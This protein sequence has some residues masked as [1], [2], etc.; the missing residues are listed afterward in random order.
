MSGYLLI[1]FLESQSKAL[2]CKVYLSKDAVF[3][4]PATVQAALI[5]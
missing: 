3:H 5:I 1:G 4:T 2:I